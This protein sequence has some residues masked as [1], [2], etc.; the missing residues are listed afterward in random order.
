MSNHSYSNYPTEFVDPELSK[1]CTAK[2]ALDDLMKK[3]GRRKSLL[4]STEKDI[5]ERIPPM[6]EKHTNG[7]WNTQLEADYS[8]MYNEQLPS[9]W[10]E[11]VDISQ[12]VYVE[13]VLDKFILRYCQPGEVSTNKH[14]HTCY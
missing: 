11:V 9:N 2:I 8:D 14:L 10:I 7:I 4:L 1:Q 5:L 13:P 6:V 3:Y 12:N